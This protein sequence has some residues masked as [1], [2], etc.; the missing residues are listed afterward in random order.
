MPLLDHL[1]QPGMPL[2]VGLHAGLLV[3]AL[4]SFSLAKPLPEAIE[5]VAV[6]VVDE[7]LLRE[8]TRG[9]QT[10]R[11]AAPTQRVDR[12]SDKVEQNAPGVAAR[13][14]DTD[15][16]PARQ[17]ATAR[18]ERKEVAALTPPVPVVPPRAAEQPKPVPVPAPVRAPQPAKETDEEEAEEAIRQKQIKR[19]EPPKPDQAALAK[20]LDQQKRDEQKKAEDAKNREELRKQVEAKA[21]EDRKKAEDQKKAQDAAKKAAD[22]KRKRE[23]EQEARNQ[24]ALD[25]ARRALLSSREAP[26][27]SGN[28]G[29]VVSRV[30]AAG[31]ATATGQ[32]LNPSD[33]AALVGLLADQIRAC[34]NIP[35]SARPNPLP[36]VRV[37]LNADG[38]LGATPALIN[39]SGDPAF[40]PLADS[41]M[42]AIRQCSP[43]RIPARFAPTYNDWRSIVVQ[44]DPES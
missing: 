25:A 21:T 29:Q 7:S 16:A 44:L 8:V 14:I 36:Q 34:W 15:K 10:A 5:A 6:E 19:P 23:A 41:G 39:A 27:N 26:Q 24:Q 13:Q 35:V 42:R 37:A 22:E 17:E 31:T 30:P 40:R 20:L 12:V 3:A 1:R 28:T 33:R 11:Q 43:F 4:V 38:T 2:S 32:R 9:E 18:E